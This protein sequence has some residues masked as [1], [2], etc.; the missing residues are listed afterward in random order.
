MLIPQYLVNFLCCVTPVLLLLQASC[1]MRS[2]K[3]NGK[4]PPEFVN[5]RRSYGKPVMLIAGGFRPWKHKIFKYVVSIR[6]ARATAYFGDNHFCVGSIISDDLILTAAHCVVDRR[7]IVTRS[8]RLLVVA[9]TPNRLLKIINTFE[10]N[11]EDV[12]PHH[13]FVP[14]GAHDIALLRTY[15]S[16]PDDNDLIKIIPMARKIAVAGTRCQIIGWGHLFFRGPYSAFAIVANVTIFSYD[17]CK[18]F[19]PDVFDET[20]ICAGNPNAM[21]TDACRGDSG[22]PL[23]CDGVVTGVVAWSSYCA[24]EWKPIVFMSVFH[25]RDW[26]K[27]ASGAEDI[28]D[29]NAVMLLHILL[30]FLCVLVY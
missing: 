12:L 15:A 28:R 14:S 22:G 29:I 1:S 7:K 18:S 16:F 5:I 20:M 4:L 24:E 10:V 17:Y 26:I 8:H 23:I 13:R 30:Y 21:D 25:H 6:T 27:R 3:N 9:G 11:V 2:V 19:Y